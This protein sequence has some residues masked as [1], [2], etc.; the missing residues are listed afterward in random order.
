MT[1]CILLVDDSA[2]VRSGLRRAFEFQGWEVCGEAKNGRE[3]IEKA[4]QLNPNVIVLDLAMP[5]MNGITAARILK[6]T[7]PK[8]SLILFTT[9]GD[10]LGAEDARAAGIS[11]IVAK[12]E[13]IA[14]LLK[15]AERLV[16]APAA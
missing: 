1:K 4:E 3:G 14:V 8:I 13:P 12:T 16:A 6:R 15:A 10:L 7:R 11:A 5:E 2:I 9:Y